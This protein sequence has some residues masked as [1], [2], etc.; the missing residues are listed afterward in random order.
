MS[1]ESTEMVTIPR[2]DLDA[3]KAEA[4]RRAERLGVMKRCP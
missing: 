4:R 2:A 1:T 3:L